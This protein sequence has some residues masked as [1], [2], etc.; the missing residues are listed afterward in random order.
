MARQFVSFWIVL[1]ALSLGRSARAAD[2]EAGPAPTPIKVKMKG[3]RGDPKLMGLKRFASQEDLD[4]TLGAGAVTLPSEVDFA[5]EDVLCVGWM[6]SPPAGKLT[7]KSSAK[8]GIAFS[9][10]RRKSKIHGNVVMVLD[11][12]FTVPKGTKAAYG[13]PGKSAEPPTP[14]AP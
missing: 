6:A 4:K 3:P 2:E 13:K 1:V 5:K 12:W 11:E 10:Q 9:V 7:W 14:P 8:D